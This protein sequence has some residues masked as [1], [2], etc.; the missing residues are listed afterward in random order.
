MRRVARAL[1]RQFLAGALE[2]LARFLLRV[3]K[4]REIAPAIRAQRRR[5]ACA[6]RAASAKAFSA[7]ARRAS[8]A[9]HSCSMAM[10]RRD[11]VFLRR[12]CGARRLLPPAAIRPARAPIPRR[13]GP[14]G[15]EAL[16]CGFRGGSCSAALRGNIFG[17]L[18]QAGFERGGLAAERGDGFFL[19][20]HAS[21]EVDDLA[22]G[23]LD[24][25]C[26]TRRRAKSS[27]AAC[28]RLKVMRF[29]AR[30]RSSAVWPSRFCVWRSS[31][32]SS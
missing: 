3:A 1:G 26:E 17:G 10:H 30:S 32:S 11:A 12:Q 18:A 19:H 25:H 9:R 5:F 27:C 23:L 24:F 15:G 29:S 6:C 13:D 20:V 8:N 2:L 21:G 16:P 7:P 28:S 22:R 14:R 4:A 31:A